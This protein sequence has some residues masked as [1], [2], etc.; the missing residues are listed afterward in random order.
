MARLLGGAVLLVACA[1]ALRR[2]RIISTAPLTELDEAYDWS[3]FDS[4]GW[5]R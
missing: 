2:L 4:T 3:L 1:L 5:A